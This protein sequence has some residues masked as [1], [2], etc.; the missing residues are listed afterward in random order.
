MVIIGNGLQTNGTNQYASRAVVST[1]VNNFSVIL[2]VKLI[3]IIG[4][5]HNVFFNNGADDG[6]GYQLRCSTAGVFSFDI[7]FVAN[8]SSGVTLS[9]DTWYQLAV[10][11][12][13]GTSQC[14]VNAVAQ[15]GTSASAPNAPANFCTIG[16][17]QT[18]TGTAS[19][20]AN[21]IIDD[22]RLYERAISTTE[23][24][25]LYNFQTNTTLGDIDRTSLKSWYKLDEFTG[26]SCADSSVTASA[27]TTT[28]SPTF[29]SGIV[30]A[31]RESK[32]L[33]NVGKPRP[34]SPGIAR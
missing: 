23:L 16:A 12:N 27:M 31:K 14:Y 13:G 25:N 6:N 21:A 5:D 32:Y 18:S 19:R 9:T 3:T 22:V 24:T 8:L 34:F 20:F 30:E 33:R 11:R 29:V 26:T 2:W 7:S 1:V 10:I 17:S 4:T 28:N 15:G